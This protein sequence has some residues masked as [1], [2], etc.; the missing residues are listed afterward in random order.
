MRM[1]T[2]PKGTFLIRKIWCGLT[3]ILHPQNEVPVVLLMTYLSHQD[4]NNG[5]VT[6]PQNDTS[7]LGHIRLETTIFE[8]FKTMLLQVVSAFFSKIWLLA[9]FTAGSGLKA[10]TLPFL[11]SLLTLCGL[12]LTPSNHK[13]IGLFY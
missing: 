8:L 2:F 12:L 5:K 7:P 3:G 9:V 1:Q 10:G 11:T 6:L 4:Y 13:Y